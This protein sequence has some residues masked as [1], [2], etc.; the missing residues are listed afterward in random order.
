MTY[1]EIRQTLRNASSMVNKMDKAHIKELLKILTNAQCT[2]DCAFFLCM[3]IKKTVKKL[4]FELSK[5]DRLEDKISIKQLKQIFAI[6]GDYDVY[7]TCKLCGQ[8]I[9]INSQTLKDTEQPQTMFTWDHL[10]P[11]SL[12][13]AG[14]LQNLQPA[15]KIC[16]NKKADK[17]IYYKHYKITIDIDIDLNPGGT[18][19]HKVSH[20]GLRK[21]DSWCHKNRPQHVR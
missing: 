16:N 18:T 1:T 9:I 2:N 6:M 19:K 8:P 3:D 12:G 17:L 10:F 14:T 20:I 5:S 7:P 4:L 21:Q 13:G 11:K 15:H